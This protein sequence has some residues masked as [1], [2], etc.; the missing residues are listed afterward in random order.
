MIG[1]QELDGTVKIA[2]QPT[3]KNHRT[4]HKIV[5]SSVLSVCFSNITGKVKYLIKVVKIV[6]RIRSPIEMAV[7][8][9]L[10]GSTTDTNVK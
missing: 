9:L 1:N 6:N 4:P 10:I 5:I 2:K 3:F 8:L 7:T